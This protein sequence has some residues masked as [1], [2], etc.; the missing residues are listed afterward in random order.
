MWSFRRMIHEP[1]LWL[2]IFKNP[3]IKDFQACLVIFK[4]DLIKILYQNQIFLEIREWKIYKI[5]SMET[6]SSKI[7]NKIIIHL[8]DLIIQV[9]SCLDH[10]TRTLTIPNSLKKNGTKIIKMFIPNLIIKIISPQI[11]ITH[12]SNQYITPLVSRCMDS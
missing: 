7:I 10:L 4:I 5:W 11:L 9:I 1:K 8:A 3:S 2:T 6:A 12:Q